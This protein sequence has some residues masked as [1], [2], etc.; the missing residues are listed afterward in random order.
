MPGAGRGYPPDGAPIDATA[1][2]TCDSTI[3]HVRASLPM[4]LSC[5]ACMYRPQ[6]S[7]GDMGFA[8]LLGLEA[9]GSM[10]GETLPST[11]F[12]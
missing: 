5:R 4:S 10:G 1:P 11:N 9:A 8:D 3:P 2:D 7:A 6:N 12:W